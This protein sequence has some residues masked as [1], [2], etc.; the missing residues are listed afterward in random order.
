MQFFPEAAAPP[1][2]SSG[3]KCFLNIPTGQGM[4]VTVDLLVDGLAAAIKDAAVFIETGYTRHC[5]KFT[6]AEGN[7]A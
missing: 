5:Q 7:C 3:V 6:L 2:V 4:R 1:K